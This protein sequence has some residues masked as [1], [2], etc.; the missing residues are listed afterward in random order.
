MAG[1]R[2]TGIVCRVSRIRWLAL[3]LQFPINTNGAQ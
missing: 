1:F 2:K 3:Y